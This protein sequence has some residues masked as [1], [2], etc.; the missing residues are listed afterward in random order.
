MAGAC[1]D[2]CFEAD[3][4]AAQ[5]STHW[6]YAGEGRGAY[7]SN[8]EITY[9]GEGR[10]AYNKEVVTNTGGWRLRPMW[11]LCGCFLCFLPL[12]FITF[13]FWPRP[14]P[15][16]D[17]PEKP[18]VDCYTGYYNGMWRETWD[19]D[20]AAWCCAEMG[21][22]CPAHDEVPVPVPAPRPQ[23][24]YNCNA[25][26]SDWY[27]GWSNHKKGWCCSHVRK[28]CPGTWH[29]S[30][31]FHAHMVHGVG[32]AHGKIYDCA[33]GFSNW[34]QGWSDSK[35]DWCCKRENRGCVKFH[36]SGEASAWHSGTDS[37]S[38]AA[39]ISRRAAQGPPFLH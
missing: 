30:Y 20:H 35:K 2:V 10:G 26:F 9:V 34:M 28:G 6:V 15:S 1:Y 32:H 16:R 7:Q 4:A 8:T 25:G 29:G 36:C 11:Y 39:T 31:H 27:W 24:H 13:W 17:V 33:A 38:T 23:F 5:Q 19:V 14:V 37:E 12:F 21:R 18:L 22:G 3:P